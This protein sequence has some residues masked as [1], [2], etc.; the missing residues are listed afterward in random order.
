MH[1]YHA[2]IPKAERYTIWQKCENT[3]LALL[4]ALIAT[5]QFSG[6]ERLHS[7]HNLSNKLDLLKVFIRLAQDTR[8]IDAKQYLALQTIL[9]EIGK[10]VGGW[11]KSIHC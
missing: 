10:M 1:S 11:I 7:L 8:S 6:E 3:T 9:Q 2:R 5:S 4:E